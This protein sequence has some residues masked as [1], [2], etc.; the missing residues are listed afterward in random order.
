MRRRR[1][2]RS[3]ERACPKCARM[4][5][6]DRRCSAACRPAAA[7]SAAASA[8]SSTVRP[9]GSCRLRRP[10]VEYQAE[11]AVGNE[12]ERMRRIDRLRGQDRQDLLAEMVGQPFAARVRS[13][14][15][16]PARRVLSA[17]ASRSII[18]SACWA[19]T[20]E[21]ASLGNRV[22][23]LRRRSFRRRLQ[24][25]DALQ[26]LALQSGD[27]D[28]EEFVE[29]GSRNRQEAQPFEQRMAGWSPPPAR[30]G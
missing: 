17:R 23:L 9:I 15:R 13:V 26:L 22:E 21:S 20:S 19:T 14:V 28:H 24:F 29:I 12:R 4:T 27:A 16:R 2:C 7:R 25:L 3:R 1:P 18:H 30:A 6:F 10:K 11:P 8:G 5:A